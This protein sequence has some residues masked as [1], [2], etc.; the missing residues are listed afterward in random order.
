LLEDWYKPCPFSIYIFYW[1]SEPR[2][3]GWATYTQNRHR[4]QNRVL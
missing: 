3:D 1:E 2:L 4:G